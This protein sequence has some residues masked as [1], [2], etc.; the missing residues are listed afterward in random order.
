[1]ARPIVTVVEKKSGCGCFLLL[2][3]M[4]GVGL[5]LLTR[6]SDNDIS[7][8]SSS[9]SKIDDPLTSRKV[10]DEGNSAKPD[11]EIDD[12]LTSRKVEDERNS[13][14]PDSDHS[15]SNGIPTLKTKSG[16]DSVEWKVAELKSE[17][18]AIEIR[19]Q[20]ERARWQEAVNLINRLT[21][22]KR[23][24]VIEGSPQYHQCMAASRVIKE[25]E[26][27]APKLKAEKAR[28]ESMIQS[29]DKQ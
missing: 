9:A 6:S 1:M 26:V 17:L 15:K 27:G 16:K 8:I 13:V 29:L 4:C 24:P 21:N 10:E 3:L 5:W 20:A 7:K 11:S 19:I 2:I 18:A 14:K 25:V 28:L 22:F 23:T 12:P